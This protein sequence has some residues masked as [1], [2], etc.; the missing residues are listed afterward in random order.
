MKCDFQK[1][2]KEDF[3]KIYGEMESAF[4]KE[5]RRSFDDAYRVLDN[6]KYTLYDIV[7]DGEHIGFISLWQLRNMMF[8]EHFAILEA[9]RG[10]GYGSVV[11]EALKDRYENIILEAE[12]PECSIASR[13]IAFYERAGFVVNNKPYM[14]PSYHGAEGVR[15]VIM[16][17]P[18]LLRDFDGTVKELYST[19]YNLEEI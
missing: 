9:C 1:I 18:S 16:S 5:E 19:V 6:E 11:L 4:I 10:K 12:P 3:Q 2:K 14:Q 15:L 8:I 17:Y 13:R 7:C